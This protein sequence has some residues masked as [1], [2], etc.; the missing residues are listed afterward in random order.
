MEFPLNSDT[1]CAFEHNIQRNSKKE[2]NVKEDS[3]C[4]RNIQRNKKEEQKN[5]DFARRFKEV[6]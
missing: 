4:C 2:N 5:P 6:K 1:T 3:R